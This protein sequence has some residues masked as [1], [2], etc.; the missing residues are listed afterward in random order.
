MKVLACLPV[1]AQCFAAMITPS[2]I[3]NVWTRR[4]VA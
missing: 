3:A 4:V 2:P 1:L